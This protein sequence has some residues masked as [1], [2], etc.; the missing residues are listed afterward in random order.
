MER[1]KYL[2][3]LELGDQS[4]AGRRRSFVSLEREAEVL[5]LNRK[6]G[7]RVNR[8]PLRLERARRS[9]TGKQRTSL[10]LFMAGPHFSTSSLVAS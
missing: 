6:F 7:K 2:T 1:R 9:R 3:Y 8:Q 4:G 5:G 10:I